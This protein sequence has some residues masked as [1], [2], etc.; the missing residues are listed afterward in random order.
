M[1]RTERKI[2]KRLLRD[3][4]EAM[5]RH[6]RRLW[7][8]LLIL[9]FLA[10]SCALEAY[11]CAHDFVVTGY[12]FVT[13]KVSSPV[14]F[15]LVGDL[16]ESEFG[17]NNSKLVEAVRAQEPD[18]ILCTGDMI[19]RNISEDLLHIGVDFMTEMA[20]IAPVYMSLGNHES[21]YVEKHGRGVLDSLEAAGVVL[22]DKEYV[23][24]DINGQTVRIGGI[25]DY[26]FKYGQTAEEY[27]ASEKYAFLTSFCD[28]DS[29]KILLCHRPVDYRL[30]SMLKYYE[31]WDTDL[32]LSGHTH[33]GLWQI[34]FINK[35]PYLPQQGF[36][37]MLDK[38]LKD[39]GNA[40]MIITAGLGSEPGLFRLNDPCE[41]VSITLLP[42]GQ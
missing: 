9:S 3:D 15:V 14:R 5:D 40:Q 39:L 20:G 28:T 33:G 38:G 32:V 36:L 6:S 11:R 21:I 2:K 41:L 18:V 10:V 17:E 12:E 26:C 4:A 22:L 24:A 1:T 7:A 37:P 29:Y 16:H 34:P 35:S 27:E 23:D 31:D 13:E 25:Y 19:T 42:D 30:E 8:V